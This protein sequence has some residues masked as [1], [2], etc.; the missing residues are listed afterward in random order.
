MTTAEV[1]E[2]LGATL[3]GRLPEK[4]VHRMM[5]TLGSWLPAQEANVQSIAEVQRGIDAAPGRAPG[6]G[7]D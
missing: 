2:L 3:H 7:D 1:R 6:E 4:T 5:A